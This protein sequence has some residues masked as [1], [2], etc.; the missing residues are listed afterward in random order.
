MGLSKGR[1]RD[2]LTAYPQIE[3]P[4]INPRKLYKYRAQKKGD[5][6]TEHF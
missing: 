2:K 3:T 1:I 6:T 5:G 4:V